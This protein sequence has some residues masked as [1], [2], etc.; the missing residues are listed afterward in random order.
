[1]NFMSRFKLLLV[2]SLGFDVDYEV[3]P[4]GEEP[5]EE[6]DLE[7]RPHWGVVEESSLP[8]LH[9]SEQ[10]FN[11]AHRM[12]RGSIRGQGLLGLQDTM[13]PCQQG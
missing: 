2:V 7:D 11:T 13:G 6:L 1:M 4:E 12:F 3:V 9:C 8:F 10:A 5:H